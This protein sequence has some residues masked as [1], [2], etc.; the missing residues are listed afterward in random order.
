MV[1]CLQPG[2]LL[3]GLAGLCLQPSFFSLRIHLPAHPIG[4]LWFP[5]GPRVVS[6]VRSRFFQKHPTSLKNHSKVSTSCSLNESSAK[7]IYSVALAMGHN[8]EAHLECSSRVPA[9]VSALEKMELTPK[10]RGSEIIQL[11]DFRTATVEDIASVHSRSYVFGLE[12]V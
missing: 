6:L 8:K 11:Q 2:L 4:G 3:P 5:F 12:K 10:I 7:V 1:L 9:I